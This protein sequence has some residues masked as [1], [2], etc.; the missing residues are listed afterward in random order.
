MHVLL[1]THARDAFACE[2]RAL[3]H[4]HRRACAGDARA[5][6]HAHSW[7][8]A[9]LRYARLRG[10]LRSVRSSAPM[11]ALLDALSREKMSA[12]EDERKMESCFLLYQLQ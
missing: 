8:C 11:H 4:A 12:I 3:K 5:P 6:W 1:S 2:A 10:A 7:A 9:G